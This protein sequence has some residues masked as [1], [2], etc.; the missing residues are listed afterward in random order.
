MKFS[1][2]LCGSF[3][4]FRLLGFLHLGLCWSPGETVVACSYSKE[5]LVFQQWLSWKSK[6]SSVHIG[7]F[8]CNFAF[9]WPLMDTLI[10]LGGKTCSRLKFIFSVFLKLSVLPVPHTISALSAGSKSILPAL[11]LC[12]SACLLPSNSQLCL[13]LHCHFLCY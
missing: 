2:R 12:S 9:V 7:C 13:L 8:L 3:I 6:L 1:L 10:H 4:A 11:S 5:N